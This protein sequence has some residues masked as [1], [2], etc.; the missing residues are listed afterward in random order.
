MRKCLLFFLLIVFVTAVKGQN[1]L[2]DSLKQELFNA[3][4]DTT[5]V[6]ILVRLG[7][8][9][10]F[11]YADTALMYALQALQLAQRLNYESG[12]AG[13]QLTMCRALTNLGNYPLALN[14]GFKALAF[15]KKSKFHVVWVHGMQ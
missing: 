13:A 7:G 4:E 15:Y 3:K 12:T 2:I 14:Y 11:S 10:A 5:K 8:S 1:K 9:Y 6:L